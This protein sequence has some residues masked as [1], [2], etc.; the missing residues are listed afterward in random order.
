M[1]LLI[2]N[3]IGKAF[4][5]YKS[6]W[7]RFANWFGLNIKPADE[8]WVLRHINFEIHTGEAIGII[9]QNGAGKSTLLKMITGTLQ[10]TEGTIQINGRIAAILELG[11][12]FNP[13]LTGRQNVFN[14]AGLMGFSLEQIQHA[15]TG[16]EAFAEIGEYFDQAVRIYSSGMQ[17]RVAFA[18]ATAFKP[19]ILIVDEALAV[20]DA[21]F[22]RK[23]FRRI[24]K[25]MSD[26]MTLL[27]VTHDIESIKKLCTKALFLKDGS[28]YNYGESKKV[29]DDY[30][31]YLFGTV[32][33]IKQDASEKNSIASAE[34]DLF[35]PDLLCKG[36][37]NYGDGRAIIEDVWFENQYGSRINI[38]KMGGKF[39]IRY[40]VLFTDTV[41]TPVFAFLIKTLEGISLYGTDTLSLGIGSSSYSAG[42]YL[43]ILFNLDCHLSA[44]TYFINCGV[45]DEGSDSISFLH[46]RVDVA[47]FKVIQG[48]D[49]SQ[50]GL[51]NLSATFTPIEI[52]KD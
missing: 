6:E 39:T 2:V 43:D 14:A 26:G 3:N 20:G 21:A 15:M 29:C 13:E 34:L 24:E 10:P 18:V 48:V 42:E 38:V 36:D 41:K 7:H 23:C 4:R 22:Q 37:L 49:V 45:R 27:L 46:R 9:G 51:V 1:S 17:V 44:G 8:H 32:D 5:S 16:I 35:D 31:K 47:M 40:R 19:N 25:Y 30:E 12:G 52:T 33:K 50:V 28:Q 11:M